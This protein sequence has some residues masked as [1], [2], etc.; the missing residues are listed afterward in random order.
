MKSS[1][2]CWKIKTFLELEIFLLWKEI[3]VKSSTR[4]FKNFQL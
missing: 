1:Q 2:L 3:I 4:T